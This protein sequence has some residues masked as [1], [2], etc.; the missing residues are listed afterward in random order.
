MRKAKKANRTDSSVRVG[1]GSGSAGSLAA[2]RPGE[3]GTVRAL[4]DTGPMRR[5]L[6]DT[7]K[8]FEIPINDFRP[9]AEAIV[10]SGGIDVREVDPRT[11]MSR[12]VPGLYFAGEILDVDAYTGGYNLQIA[13]STGR[14]A[15]RAAAAYRPKKQQEEHNR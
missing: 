10:T 9:L 12:L 8:R 3:Y 4:A 7:C 15:G 1:E 14:S 5:R 6:L 13:F 11:M 2:L